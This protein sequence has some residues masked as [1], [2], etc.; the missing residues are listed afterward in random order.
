[1]CIGLGLAGLGLL[2]FN[3]SRKLVKTGIKTEARVVDIVEYNDGNNSASGVHR[4][5]IE[6]KLVYEYT[7]RSGS[8][9]RFKSKYRSKFHSREK[10][11]DTVKII[12][13]PNN[14]T[15]RIDSFWDL[16]FDPIVSWAMGLIAC[17][18]GSRIIRRF[19]YDT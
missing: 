14:I 4:N 10:I 2:E 11:G 3:I 17:I 7:D 8:P 6:Y 13:H 15:Q 12:Y 18:F 1:M 5:D 9:V 16:Y 19:K